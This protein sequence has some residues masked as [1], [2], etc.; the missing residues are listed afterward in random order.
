MRVLAIGAHPDDVELLCGGTLAL[1]A[2][3][4]AELYIAVATNGEVGS[5]YGT[6]EQI[7]ERRHREAERAATKLGATLI[8][9]GFRD[10]FLFNNEDSRLRFIDA[11]RQSDPDVMFIHSP[12]DYHP[13]HR[14]A[15]EVAND[16][17]IP[18]SV[19]LIE[20]KYPACSVPHIFVMD[21]LDGYDFTP[22]M[23]VDI[24]EVI[25]TKAEVLAEHES[26]R[27][28]LNTAYG[29]DYQ[30]SMLKHARRRGSVAGIEYGEAFRSVQ[31][32]PRVGGPDLL[33]NWLTPGPE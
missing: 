20:T 13:D 16:A 30:A 31:S 21:T 24:G 19:P 15:G 27:E 1:Y 29:M 11:I 7:A 10:E 22:E 23:I 8:W 33:P 26:Q 17:R 14:V 18:A 4:G 3:G 9:M 32:F 12:T 28:W 25:E 2:A 5:S 6:R